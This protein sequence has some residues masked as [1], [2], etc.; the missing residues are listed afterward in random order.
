MR[1]AIREIV[2]DLPEAVVTAACV[3]IFLA[4]VIG[5]LIVIAT[6]IPDVLQ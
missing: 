6:P 1:E 3:M 4:G 5:L 2:A